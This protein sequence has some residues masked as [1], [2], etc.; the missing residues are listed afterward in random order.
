[1]RFYKVAWAGETEWELSL[2]V[3]DPIFELLSTITDSLTHTPSL[4]SMVELHTQVARRRRIVDIIVWLRE[5]WYNI[6]GHLGGHIRVVSVGQDHRRALA[7][8]GA[9]RLQAELARFHA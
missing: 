8:E 6:A 4:L 7:F 2:Q 3:L 9:L 5:T 1:M